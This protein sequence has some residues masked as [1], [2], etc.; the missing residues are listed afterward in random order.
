MIGIPRNN[1]IPENRAHLCSQESAIRKSNKK[2][3]DAY[4][5][6]IAPGYKTI[7]HDLF[8]IHIPCRALHFIKKNNTLTAR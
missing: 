8:I 1:V 7:V 6:S 4:R 5:F 3:G 2:S